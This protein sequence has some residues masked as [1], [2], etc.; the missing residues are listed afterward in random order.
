MEVDR[1]TVERRRL[2]RLHTLDS[3]T[4]YGDYRLLWFGN[5]CG[6]NAQWLQLLTAGWLVRELTAGTASS[7]FHVITVGGLSTLP[8]L[9]VGPWAG[10]LGDRVD[11]RKLLMATQAVLACVAV[12][13]ALLVASDRIQE[14]W[15]VYIY[16]LIGGTAR[17]ITL[18]MQQTLIANTVPREALSN[19]YATNVI[20]IP[21]TRMIGPFIGG[22]LI[23]TVG[24]TWNFVI[25]AVLYISVVL[26]LLPMRTPYRQEATA[27][28]DSPLANMKEGIRYV[29]KGER[30]I[31]NMM[32]LTLVP[33]VLLHPTWFLLPIFT[34]EV[35]HRGADY[36][37]YFMATT[38]LGGL[39]C[40]LIIASV[41]FVYK[42][43]MI[44]LVAV[45]TSSITV[46]LFARSEWLVASFILIGLMAFSQAAFRTTAGALIQLLS[47][48]ALRARITGLYQCGQGSVIFASLLIGLFAKHTS[49]PFAV[50]V[51]GLIGLALAVLF[52]LTY[53]RMRRL[54]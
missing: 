47:P 7:A 43:G 48:D 26:V 51:V 19:A 22:I 38:G 15:H 50:T 39:L 34:A 35:F 54:E 18:A 52:L 3:L 17:S 25:E 8:V 32:V 29:W 45:I 28:Q 20:A 27:V 53:D 2:P 10:V 33:N 4:R 42:K 21:G 30:V 49:A 37:G 41:G 40:A 9:I 36:G 16:V 14:P 44:C 6:N 23:A 46:I 11:R 1:G 31:F 5:F 24:F 12:L 13:F